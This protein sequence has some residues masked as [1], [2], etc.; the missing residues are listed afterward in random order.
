MLVALVAAGPRSGASAWVWRGLGR[1]AA[2][3]ARQ[4]WPAGEIAHGQSGGEAAN[5]YGAVPILFAEPGP[6]LCLFPRVCPRGRSGCLVPAIR[7]LFLRGASAVKIVRTGR[8]YCSALIDAE[9]P[10]YRPF[11]SCPVPF[12]PFPSL[13]AS[14]RRLTQTAFGIVFF[15][16]GPPN[17]HQER[18]P[19]PPPSSTSPLPILFFPSIPLRSLLLRFLTPR[20]SLPSALHSILSLKLQYAELDS[21]HS[22]LHLGCG[23]TGRTPVW[24]GNTTKTYGYRTSATHR[25]TRR[26]EG[27]Q[28]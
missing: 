16:L 22:R 17:H 7:N 27:R 8:D 12:C 3:T 5:L 11:L 19:V 2:L 1:D 9:T 4:G 15:S 23:N 6:R 14:T 26:R 24:A 13:P 25:K 21:F 20:H 18:P 10:P 28:S